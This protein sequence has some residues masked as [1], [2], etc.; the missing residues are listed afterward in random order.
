MKQQFL[1]FFSACVLLMGVSVFS[2]KAQERDMPYVIIVEFTFSEDNV[3]Q[4]IEYLVDMQT[5][6]LDNEEGC[7]AYDVLLSEDDAT[8]VFLYESYENDTAYKKHENSAYFKTLV[9]Q[10]LKPLIKAQRI[11]KVVPVSN[12]VISDEEF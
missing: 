9:V 4:A 3:D 6:T 5:Q 7:T 11:T 8:K 10:K 1:H 2:L 12:E